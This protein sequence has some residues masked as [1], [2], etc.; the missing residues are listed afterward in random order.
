[1]LAVLT[2]TVAALAQAVTPCTDPALALRCPDLVMA[3]P[4]HLR[5]Q[6]TKAGRRVLRME[7]RIVNIGQIPAEFFG[8]RV[9]RLEMRARQVVVDGAGVRRRVETGAELYYTSVPSR[10]G[11]YWKFENAARFE[12]WAQGPDGRQTA[13]VRVGP[14][15]NYC[16]RDLDR[17]R[18]GPHVP[19]RRRFGA[20]NQ[21]PRK[22]EVTI[23][24]S[25]G[26]ADVYPASYPGNLIEV[27]GLAGCFVVVHRVDP[28]NHVLEISDANNASA[29]VVRLPYRRGPQGCPPY[30]AARSPR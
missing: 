27:T 25:V 11:D 17:V 28:A 4:S 18:T 20:C 3:P 7:N 5:V 24:T 6:R 30:V 21:S 1:V 23:G 14:K 29:K 22:T 9:S 2:A 10:G 16:L 13:L 26:W 19:R 8:R 15:L 12:L